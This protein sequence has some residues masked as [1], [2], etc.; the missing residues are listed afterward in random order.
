VPLFR[1]ADRFFGRATAIAACWT[2]AVV[3]YFMSW[4]AAWVWEVAFSAFFVVLLIDRATDLPDAAYRPWLLFGALGA[5]AILTNPALLTV[6][7][8]AALWAV[9]RSCNRKLAFRHALLAGVVCVA[10]ISPWLMRN[11][12]ALGKWCFIRDNFAFEFA[13]G[14]FPGGSG[15]GWAGLHPAINQHVMDEYATKGE[16][17]F[18]ADRAAY[19]KTWMTQHTAEF[20]QQTLH[21]FTAFWDGTSQSWT[22]FASDIWTPLPFFALTILALLGCLLA[23]GQGVSGAWLMGLACLLYPW[24]YYIT[25]AQTRYRHAIE[26]L[27]VVMAA[28]F[29]VEFAR[30]AK[31][32]FAFVRSAASSR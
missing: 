21:R 30:R 1:V 6:L 13:I 2:W 31:E 25:Y 16:I 11:R 20:A 23:I 32:R 27:L 24:P 8:V 12:V 26:P 28:Y 7:P 22:K 14:N 5:I 19:P 3:P 4:P 9:W 17:A 29:A 15:M 10:V 18:L